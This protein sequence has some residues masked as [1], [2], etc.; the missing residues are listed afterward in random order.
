MTVLDRKKRGEIKVLLTFR[1]TALGS[2]QLQRAG[3]VAA[4]GIPLV[5]AQLLA[6][7]HTYR[8][9]LVKAPARRTIASITEIFRK[10]FIKPM[11]NIY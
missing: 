4:A 9:R 8:R 6:F 3:F 5:I 10:N 2:A 11:T 1:A 7:I